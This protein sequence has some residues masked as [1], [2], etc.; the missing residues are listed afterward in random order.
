MRVTIHQ[1]EHLP[2]LGLL[3]KVAASELWVVLDSVP[4][5]KN[6][7]QNRNRV[8]LD[9]RPT[10]LTVPVTAPFGTR[11]RDVQIC[12]VPSW[13]RRYRGRLTQAVSGT[14]CADRAGDLL[15]LI[16][17]APPGGSLADL[18]LDIAD[19][20][21]AQFDVKVPMVRASEL[22]ATGSNTEL[23][24]SLC[25]ATGAD[26]YLSGP[27]GRDYLDLDAFAEQGIAV[28][29]FDFDHPLYAQGGE[30]FVPCLSAVDAWSRL[31]PAEL[32]RLLSG[33]RLSAS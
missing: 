10:W 32:P 14:R 6:Y 29:F 1:P 13:R 25:R 21:L 12:E 33:Y 30:T 16:D 26:E 7:F 22:D 2:W 17:A 9:G 28:R 8:L 31:D 15:S 19:W 20:L 5:R 24:V 3:A 18:N 23:L 4:Y 11:I 27:S